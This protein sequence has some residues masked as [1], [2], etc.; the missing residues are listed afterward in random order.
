MVP[1]EPK[2]TQSEQTETEARLK[3]IQTVFTDYKRRKEQ[4]EEVREVEEKTEQEYCYD[5]GFFYGH[6]NSQTYS[7]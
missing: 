2:I 1:I 4:E 3:K 7:P 6:G 5:G